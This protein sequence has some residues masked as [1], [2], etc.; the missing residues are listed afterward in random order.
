MCDACDPSAREASKR[1]RLVEARKFRYVTTQGDR[2]VDP[3]D[4]RGE[5]ATVNPVSVT[6]TSLGHTDVNNNECPSQ[7]CTAS[8]H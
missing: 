5:M 4:E 1:A 8:E 6:G 7:E 2:T 3:E